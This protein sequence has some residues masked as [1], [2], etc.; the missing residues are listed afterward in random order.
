MRKPVA[1][2]Q[3][4]SLSFGW[5]A[6]MPLLMHACANVHFLQDLHFPFQFRVF[7]F[8]SY[9]I[10]DFIQ[11]H[12]DPKK[13]LTLTLSVTLV[14]IVSDVAN[15]VSTWRV[16]LRIHRVRCTRTPFFQSSTIF[17][18]IACETGWLRCCSASIQF[19]NA[20][21][22]RLLP[23]MGLSIYR[24]IAAII[25]QIKFADKWQP[26]RADLNLHLQRSLIQR[27]IVSFMRA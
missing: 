12:F 3:T 8:F 22:D 16:R 9:T 21:G 27:E 4:S 13:S 7:F 1:S 5:G 20:D 25:A 10:Y 18:V 14:Q 17:G 26:V 6:L 11:R 23:F 19:V 15:L 24:I 2:Q